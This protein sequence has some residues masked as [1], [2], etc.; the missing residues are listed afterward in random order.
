MSRNGPPESLP[1]ASGNGVENGQIPTVPADLSDLP[2]IPVEAAGL[3]PHL[4][5]E[6][7]DPFDIFGD[8]GA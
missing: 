3:L 7:D 1:N 6:A 4:P 2:K 5:A 8:V